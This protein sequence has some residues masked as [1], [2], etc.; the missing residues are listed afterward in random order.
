[1]KNLTKKQAAK[2]SKLTVSKSTNAYKAL[3]ELLNG[4]NYGFKSTTGIARTGTS[5]FSKGW[6]KKSVWTNEL[7]N[8]LTQLDIAHTT[9]NDAP[10]GGA[11]GEFVKITDA[12]LIG[13]INKSIVKA[14]LE[15]E[16]AI[17]VANE[18]RIQNYIAAEK[19][20]ATLPAN[21]QF[22]NKW[23]NLDLKTASG[24]S[25][26]DFRNELKSNFPAEWEILKAKFKAKQNING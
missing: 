14:K 20:I 16:A 17:V 3:V 13:R 25:W 26:S 7:S 9:G 5:G 6:A 22:E 4:S 1:M 18:K 8:L 10:R 23:N 2:F 21:E 12:R 19:L 11:S 24:L 15:H